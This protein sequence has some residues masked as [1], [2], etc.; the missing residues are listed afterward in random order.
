M[1]TEPVHAPSLGY[2]LSPE[3]LLLTIEEAARVLSIGRTTV[4]TLMGS[5]ELTPVYIGRSCRISRAELERYVARKDAR[6][7]Q[8][9]TDAA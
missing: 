7:T 2:Q 6:S 9:S 1:T 5:G 8:S 4:Y 3:Q